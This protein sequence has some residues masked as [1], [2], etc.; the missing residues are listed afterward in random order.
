M[1][2]KPYLPKGKELKTSNGCICKNEYKTGI[3][4][5]YKE[6]CNLDD[7]KFSP[8]CVVDGKCGYRAETE[9]TKGGMWWDHCVAKAAHP[10]PKHGENYYTRNIKGIIIYVII[11]VIT[12][13]LLLYKFGYHRFL[14]VYMPNFD[15]LATAISFEGGPGNSY[16]FQELYEGYPENLLGQTS[17]LLINYMSLLGLTYLIARRVN[18]T[19]SLAKGWGIGFVMLFLTYLVPNNII[20]SAQHKAAKYLFKLQPGEKK[21]LFEYLS[22]VSIGL[23]ISGMF[24]LAEAHIIENHK[25]LIDPF[26]KKLLHVHTFF[27]NL[28]NK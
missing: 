6:Q 25:T 17:T 18:L 19:K 26:I 16:I 5:K 20:M 24:I 28:L 15:L 12:I 3:G 23:G 27:D 11:F 8:W 13:P 1:T 21:S 4:K 2:E 7:G 14:E 22:I 10:Q 9:G